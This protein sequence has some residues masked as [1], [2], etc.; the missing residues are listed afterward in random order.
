[1]NTTCRMLAA[2]SCVSVRVR[3]ACVLGSASTAAAL[4]LCSDAKKFWAPGP[5][6]HLG[7]LGLHQ[8]IGEPTTRRARVGKDPGAAHSPRPARLL[9]L[10]A[11]RQ[12]CCLAASSDAPRGAPRDPAGTKH[13]LP[14]VVL[15][16]RHGVVVAAAAVSMACSSLAS[17]ASISPSSTRSSGL[18]NPSL[19]RKP[20]ARAMASRSGT[21]Q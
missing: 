6:N 10:P 17:S 5:R 13:L 12:D 19:R 4:F 2:S 11:R 9:I 15:T 20:P 21:A 7:L 1:M 14:P 8:R 3:A 18:M 16:V